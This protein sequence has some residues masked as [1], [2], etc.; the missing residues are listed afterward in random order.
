MFVT[1]YL[2]DICSDMS[3]FHG[4]RDITREMDGPT[5]FKLAWRLDAYNGAA[6]AAALRDAEETKQEEQEKGV[7]TLEELQAFG[8]AMPQVGQEVGLFSI[9]RIPEDS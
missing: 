8:P 5:F 1:E 9:A 2:D 4:V 6:L 7:M 3:V